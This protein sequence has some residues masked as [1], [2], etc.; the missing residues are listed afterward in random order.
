MIKIILSVVVISI[1]FSGCVGIGDT[2]ITKKS[3]QIGKTNHIVKNS[4]NNNISKRVKKT[5]KDR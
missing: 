3:M 1:V 2:G 5:N 4:K